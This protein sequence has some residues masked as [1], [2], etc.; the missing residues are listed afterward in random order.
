MYLWT[1]KSS[2][3]K[4]WLTQWLAMGVKYGSYDRGTKKTISSRNGLFKEVSQS[5]QITKNPKHC[6]QV[7][8]ASRATILDRIEKWQLK[9]Y[10]H[11]LRMEDGRWP[12]KICQ[13]TPHGRRRT[14]RQQQSWR[15]QV[16]YFMKSRN[17]EEGMAEDIFDVQE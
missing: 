8:N 12:K 15:N 16:T 10:G 1:Q 13:W 5:V 4:L 3:E 2:Q 17:I 6:Q 11:L 7:Q 9:W 14:G